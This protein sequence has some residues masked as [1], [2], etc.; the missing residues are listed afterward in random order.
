MTSKSRTALLAL[1]AVGLGASAWSTY[2]HHALLTR[3]NYRSF[4]DVN[5]TV[6]CTQAYLSQYGSVWGVPVALGGVL[7]FTLILLVAGLGGRRSAPARENVPAYVFALSVPGLAVVLYL[8]WASA[9][10]LQALCMLCV[11]TYVAV[12]GIFLVSGAATPFPLTA[13]PRRA[14]G[15]LLMLIK[16]PLALIVAALFAVGFAILVNAFPREVQATAAVQDTPYPPLTDGQR[17]EFLRWY[18]VQPQEEVPV[19]AAGAKVTIVKFNDFQCPACRE[20]YYALARVLRKY[21]GNSQ[22]RY[23]LKH[24]PLEPECN[25]G[26]PGGTHRAACE[27]AAAIEMAERQGT[28]DKVEAWLFAN[29]STL[30]P[31]TVKAGAAQAGG[32]FDF[33]AR[34][35]EALK[36]VREDAALGERLKVNSTPTFF[37]NGRRIAGSLPP[38][39]FEAAIEHELAR[40]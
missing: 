4:C 31:E 15:D 24:Y 5:G 20:S 36:S 19:D 13:L 26:V 11:V 37:I 9:F 22:V 8:A 30:S 12:A 29:L 14:R 16:S 32:I 6:S 28:A 21:D 27:A 40:K 25:G 39:A 35:A 10:R 17:A 34:Y 7:F 3:P 33:D 38:G 23:V 2:V 1:A 18:D